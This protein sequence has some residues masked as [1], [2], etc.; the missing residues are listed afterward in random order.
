MKFSHFSDIENSYNL[1]FVE[2]IDKS[3]VWCVT[4][5]IHG[6]N[7]SLWYSSEN[8]EFRVGKRSSFIDESNFFGIN[9]FSNTSLKEITINLFN[10]IKNNFNSEIK[11]LVIYGEWFGGY[12][13]CDGVSVKGSRVQTGVSYSPNNHFYA[14]YMKIN[15][16]PVS[17]KDFSEIFKDFDNKNNIFFDSKILF[18]GTFNECMEYPNDQNSFIPDM[19]NLPKLPKNIMEGV[20]IEPYDTIKFTPNNERVVLKNKNNLFNEKKNR[21]GKT[22]KDTIL[23]ENA[24]S[25]LENIDCY[26]TEQRVENLYSKLGEEMCF[27]NFSSILKEYVEDV[28]KDSSKEINDNDFELSSLDQENV[29]HEVKNKS[30][31]LIRNFLKTI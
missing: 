14:F 13:N 10:H 19:F 25:Y 16:V 22:Y 6:A 5:K 29:L 24:I 7:A 2:K 15:D 26:I 28:F 1:K 17:R 31:N 3:G 12:Y 27:K 9:K 23:S 30:S 21:T 20:V 4:E 11:D 18:K 8:D